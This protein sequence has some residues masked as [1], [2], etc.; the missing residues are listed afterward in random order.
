MPEKWLYP[1][2]MDGLNIKDIY[3]KYGNAKKLRSYKFLNFYQYLRFGKN[4]MKLIPLLNYVDYNKKTA[5]N[6]L[7]TELNWKNYGNKHDESIFTK[8]YH[9]IILPQKF[10][11]DKR[12]AHLSSLICSNQI[13]REDALKELNKQ[14]ISSQE[15]NSILEYF[16]KKLDLTK[17]EFEN[18]MISKKKEHWEFKS[19]AKIKNKIGN[20]LKIFKF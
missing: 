8:F 19:Y 1:Y 14:T 5:L 17:T 11:V 4:S 6:I 7:E 20:I 16:L 3:K 12:K 9:D 18:I 10:N 15:Y 2:K 13:S